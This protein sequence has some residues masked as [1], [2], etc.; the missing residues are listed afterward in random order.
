MFLTFDLFLSATQDQTVTHTLFSLYYFSAL[1]SR[2][3][4]LILTLLCN[5]SLL[6]HLLLLYI[7]DICSSP[8]HHTALLSSHHLPPYYTSS[9]Y[10]FLLHTCPNSTTSLVLA[11]LYLTPLLQT[12]LHSTPLSSAVTR[13]NPQP[14]ILGLIH[15]TTLVVHLLNIHSGIAHP[16]VTTVTGDH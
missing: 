2:I 5:L 9:S 1:L 7:Q 6:L 14:N 11:S 12:R 16:C 15:L 4:S 3:C 10:S 8:P 13:P